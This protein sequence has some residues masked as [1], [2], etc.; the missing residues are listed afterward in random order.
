[1]WSSSKAVRPATAERS[2]R[3]SSVRGSRSS[4]ERTASVASPSTAAEIDSRNRVQANLESGKKV[5]GDALL[6]AV[7]RQPNTDTLRLEAAGI[8]ADARGR[9]TVNENFQTA[10]PHIYAAGDVIGFSALASSSMEQGRLA[11][12]HM[13]STVRKAKRDLLPYGIYTIPEIS[14]VGKNERELTEARG[15]VRS[16][17]RQV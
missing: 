3:P 12:G 9:L 10:V 17:N 13:F 4:I 2:Q 7:G 8:T 11:S 6:Y 16:R 15:S 1:M 5:H 14:V